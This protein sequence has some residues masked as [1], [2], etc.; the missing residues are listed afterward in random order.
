MLF[1]I[2][3]RF[4][5]HSRI[6]A[7]DHHGSSNNSSSSSKKKEEERTNT[8]SRVNWKPYVHSLPSQFDTAVWLSEEEL[9]LFG[10][11]QQLTTIQ[12]R[13]K[14]NLQREY[15]TLLPHVL[16]FFREDDNNMDNNNNSNNNNNNN[17]NNIN[18]NN[19]NSPNSRVLLG[20][21]TYTLEN[22]MWAD[23]A[24]SSRMF[25]DAKVM[26]PLIDMCNHSNSPNACWQLDTSLH[27]IL[28]VPSSQPL[29]SNSNSTSNDDNNNSSNRNSN[30]TSNSQVLISYGD[31]SNEELVFQYGFALPSNPFDK[32]TLL[33]FLSEE[34]PLLPAKV[35]LLKLYNLSPKLIIT[36]QQGFTDESTVV[37]QISVA[38]ENDL[39]ILHSRYTSK[40][41][42][43]NFHHSIIII[44]LLLTLS[45]I[46]CY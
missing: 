7:P 23:A 44:L 22:W 25:S 31:K 5:P 26:F 32:V 46:T 42:Y 18:N 4:S 13:K 38:D 11:Y 43:R 37:A 30:S 21:A 24:F 20:D 27:R 45:L 36:H 28:L 19:S 15:N 9:S 14:D 8:G 41:F 40:L 33:A 2:Y 12:Q 17:N 1:L 29:P 10:N 16:Q 3:E 35:S 6:N 39:Q 34:D